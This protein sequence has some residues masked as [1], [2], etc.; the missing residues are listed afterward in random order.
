MTPTLNEG[1]GL[2]MAM[3]KIFKRYFKLK[4]E[5]N[6]IE[7]TVKNFGFKNIE[8]CLLLLTLTE[9]KHPM[10]REELAK[11]INIHGAVASRHLINLDSAK[12]IKQSDDPTDTTHNTLRRQIYTPT[13]KG[14]DLVAKLKSQLQ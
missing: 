8:E 10:L 5:M 11:Q 14:I 1:V 4:S 13:A 2:D 9:N 12:L 7:T 6:E 3:L